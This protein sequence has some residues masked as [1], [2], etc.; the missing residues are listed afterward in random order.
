MAKKQPTEDEES[1]ADITY[2]VPDGSGIKNA[3]LRE[4]WDEAVRELDED[5]VRTVPPPLS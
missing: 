1:D 4:A 3:H 5:V 2:P